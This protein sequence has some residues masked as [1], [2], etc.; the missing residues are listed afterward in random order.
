MDSHA[1][2]AGVEPGGLTHGFEIKFLVCYL[3]S[4]MKEPMTFSQINDALLHRGLVNYFELAGALGEL[5]ESGHLIGTDLEDNREDTSYRL[6]PLGAQTAKTFENTLPAS[7]KEKALNSARH[8]MLRKRIESSNHAN[9]RKTE[10]GYLVDISI[11]DIGSDLLNLTIFMPTE[12]EADL[13]KRCF[14]SDPLMVYRGVLALL[15]GDLQTA[16]QL[17]PTKDEDYEV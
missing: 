8:Q 2:T 7:V 10:D 11:C 4:Q 12:R 17:I 1:F 16:G 15:T 5:T 14:L 3:L 6:T 13:V 9:V